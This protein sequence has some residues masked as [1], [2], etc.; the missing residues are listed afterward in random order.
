M[1]N[2][3][4]EVTAKRFVY[5]WTPLVA[6]AGII[7]LAVTDVRIGLALIITSMLMTTLTILLGIHAVNK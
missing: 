4:A 6:T 3:T 5:I 7:S 2:I 1:R